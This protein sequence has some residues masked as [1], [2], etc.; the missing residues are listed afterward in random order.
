MSEI[1]NGLAFT[2]DTFIHRPPAILKPRGLSP[3]I[4]THLLSEWA[5]A[6]HLSKID[7]PSKRYTV[8]PAR[9]I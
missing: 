5:V 7:R 6:L 3:V 1:I 8:R 2:Q 9:F 4:C